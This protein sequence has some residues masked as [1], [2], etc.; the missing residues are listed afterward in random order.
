MTPPMSS[1]NNSYD[2]GNVAAAA[3]TQ[4]AAQPTTTKTPPKSSTTPIRA[5]NNYSNTNTPIAS[6]KR[7]R[8]RRVSG[9]NESNGAAQT[10]MRTPMRGVDE[11]NDDAYSN[12]SP[13]H[14]IRPVPRDSHLSLHNNNTQDLSI[15]DEFGPSLSQ[16]SEL[17]EVLAAE[18]RE[19]VGCGDASD[20]ESPSNHSSSSWVGRKVDAIFSPVLSFLHGATHGATTADA[21]T[22]A[23]SNDVRPAS[24]QSAS[25]TY[26]TTSKNMEEP[27]EELADVAGIQPSY[28][29]DSESKS[30]A[31][32]NA[33]RDALRQAAQEVKEDEEKANK[34]AGLRTINKNASEETYDDIPGMS[35]TES[36]GDG[37]V[38]ADGDVAMVDCYAQK[39]NGHSSYDTTPEYYE[40]QDNKQATATETATATATA[41]NN[42]NN[43][44]DE[45]EYDDDEEEFNPYLFIKC[46]PPYKYATPPGWEN[47]PK[48]LPPLDLNANPPIPPICLVLDLDETLVH[49]TIEPVADA[50]MVF[51][52]EFNGMEYQ[53][54]VRCRPYLR[55]FLEA[56]HKKFE[57]V[58]FTASQQVYADKLLDKI[59]PGETFAV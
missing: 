3:T 41:N 51:P 24:I 47:R 55:Q 46:L 1:S 53:V 6:A 2:N 37:N 52:V 28:S 4:A 58:I 33:I 39:S 18:Q 19:D 57:V 17:S 15:P 11:T 22:A 29:D 25:S 20:G 59:D 42:N 5:T 31:V 14:S 23:E 16:E 38:D 44:Q 21:D 56:V 30:V 35:I 12:L 49:C 34:S 54:H 26:L 27:Q 32:S 50:D 8:G 10:P 7:P 48:S 40:S 43:S 36:S 13:M 45:T 9:Q